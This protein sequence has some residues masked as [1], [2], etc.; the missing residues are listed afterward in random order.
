[1]Y[2]ETDIPTTVITRDHV[3]D[4]KSNLPEL[5]DEKRLR[6]IEQYS[7]SEDIASQLVRLN[8]V[9]DFEEIVLSSNIDPTTVGSTLAY[10][11][12]EL[13]REGL[14]V[15]KLNTNL[16]T[17]TFALVENGKIAKEA[18]SEVLTELIHDNSSPEQIASKLDLMM[19]SE[20]KVETIIDELISE[21][22]K[23]V[24]ERGMGAM[25]SLM[26]KSMQKLQGKADGK[27]VNKLLRDK[28]QNISSV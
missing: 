25:G 20:D 28:I 22:I 5:P 11:L 14:D 24:Q 19:Y 26:G 27:L 12:K 13:R 23:I 15:S 17:E 18:V 4:I 3:M 9:E 21:N 7:L 1:M 6:I 10:T 16:L 8:K 2:V